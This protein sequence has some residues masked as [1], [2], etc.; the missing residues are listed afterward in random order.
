MA[1]PGTPEVI[2]DW[3][4]KQCTGGAVDLQ[5]RL[6]RTLIEK[7]ISNRLWQ[8]DSAWGGV[9]VPTAIL[10]AEFDN[11]CPTELVKEIEAALEANQM[12]KSFNFVQLPKELE[13]SN[14]NIADK[15][16]SFG[17]YA[18]VPDFFHG[19]PWTPEVPIQDWLKKHAPVEAVEFAKQVIQALIEKGISKVVAAGFCWG[20][21]VVVELEKTADIQ[22]AAL[23]HPSFVTLDDIKAY[24]MQP[25]HFFIT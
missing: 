18:V 21:K 25:L 5:S 7:G 11:V 1:T 15:I 24:F 3:L 14:K 9:K 2:Q 23:L 16:A 17:Y 10:G 6:F 22:V 12:L 20:A 8:Q 19:D 4:K 13:S